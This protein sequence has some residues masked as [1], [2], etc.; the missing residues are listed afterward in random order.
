M[1]AVE[2]SHEEKR[3]LL[4][5]DTRRMLIYKLIISEKAKIYIDIYCINIQKYY[6]QK[7]MGGMGG[8]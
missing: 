1:Y 4:P 3:A 8:K 6:L 2:P 5:S 7:K